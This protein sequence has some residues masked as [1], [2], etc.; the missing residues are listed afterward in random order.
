V[1]DINCDMAVLYYHRVKDLAQRLLKT[2]WIIYIYIYIRLQK[3]EKKKEKKTN[4]NGKKNWKK[5]CQ[6]CITPALNR[7]LKKKF[8]LEWVNSKTM[9]IQNRN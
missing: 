7:L 8:K 2:K 4:G 3:F 1:I 5:I 9:Y 6:Y